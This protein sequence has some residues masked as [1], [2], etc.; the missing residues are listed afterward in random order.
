MISHWVCTWGPL[1]PVLKSYIVGGLYLEVP[2]GRQ[3]LGIGGKWDDDLLGKASCGGGALDGGDRQFTLF[4]TRRRAA[5]KV[6]RVEG[7]ERIQSVGIGGKW[8]D[9]ISLGQAWQGK[10]WR[11]YLSERVSSK[12]SLLVPSCSLQRCTYY[13]FMV[14]GI[15]RLL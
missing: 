3:S 7:R 15:T 13:S 11:S 12:G 9:V 10:L 6:G 14:E 1:S 2:R 4:S 8:D 5:R